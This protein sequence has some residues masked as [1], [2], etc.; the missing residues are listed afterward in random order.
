LGQREECAT[1]SIGSEL[2]QIARARDFVEAIARRIPMNDS[3]VYDL[4]LA[5]DEAVTNVIEHAYGGERGRTVELMAEYSADHFTII[6]T[7]TGPSFDPSAHPEPVMEEYMADRRVGG[8]GLYLMRQL[9][10]RIEYGVSGEGHQQIR[11]VKTRM[12]HH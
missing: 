10:D 4:V 9:M 1:I 3:E 6:V 5:V 2:D 8:L 7:H 11:M 12:A